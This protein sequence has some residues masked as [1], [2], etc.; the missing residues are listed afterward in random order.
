MIKYYI[1]IFLCGILI[2]SE[3]AP[4]YRHKR[5]KSLQLVDPV[6]RRPVVP[7]RRHVQYFLDY[8]FK[9][10]DKYYAW[11]PIDQRYCELSDKTAWCPS[12]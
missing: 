4:K 8:T 9:I 1:P 10:M 2:P 12:N 7:N 6:D 5:P 11:D 3:H